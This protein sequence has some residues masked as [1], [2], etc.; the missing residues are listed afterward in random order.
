MQKTRKWLKFLL[1]LTLTTLCA[2]GGLI[3]GCS[4][5]EP[6]V[7]KP[8]VSDI[9]VDVGDSLNP[10]DNGDWQITS[11]ELDGKVLE[12]STDYLIV[13]G[14][15]VW[16]VDFYGEWGLGEHTIKLVA[17]EENVSFKVTVTDDKAPDYEFDMGFEEKMILVGEDLTLPVV[18]RSNKYQAYN[19]EYSLV[20]KGVTDPIYVQT[21]VEA[22][23]DS[24][25][26]ADL[27]SGDYTYTVKVVKGQTEVASYSAVVKFRTQ[28]EI[29]I[30]KDIFGKDMSSG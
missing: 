17:G 13:D 30:A 1:V 23:E 20:K 22:T 2:F 24:I 5:P 14:Y 29:T 27:A 7:K 12:I 11:V 26:I 15:L 18:A 21:N 3:V 19:V 4:E 16:G 8:V 28:D 10:I 9:S 6:E 25:V